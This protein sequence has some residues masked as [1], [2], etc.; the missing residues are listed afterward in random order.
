MYQ[1]IFFLPEDHAEA[2]KTA[3]FEA[4]A[5]AFNNY[6]R[7]SWETKGTGQFRPLE[8]SNAF[9]G[10]RGRLERIP[11]L[12]VEMMC[13]DEILEAALKALKDAH[14]YEEPAYY[15]VKTVI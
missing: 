13:R 14:P 9:I 5:G 3:L 8:D 4:G 1:L 7:C 10:S 2:V 12:R 11:E 6:D 15:A